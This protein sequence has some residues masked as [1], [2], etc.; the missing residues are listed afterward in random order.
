MPGKGLKCIGGIADGQRRFWQEGAAYLVVQISP[1]PRANFRADI[2]EPTIVETRTE[3]YV[4]ERVPADG[5]MIEF[6]RP[7]DWSAAH[8]LRH[9]LT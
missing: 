9:V 2:A 4:L 6:L 8:A 3:A 1:P 7:Q 5:E